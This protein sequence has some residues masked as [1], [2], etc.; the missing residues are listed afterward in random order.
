M[1]VVLVG[2]RLGRGPAALAAVL[3]V[4]AFDFSSCRRASPLR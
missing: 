1:T 4:S 2:M 3:S